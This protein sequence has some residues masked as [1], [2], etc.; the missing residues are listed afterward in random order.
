MK[1]GIMKMNKSKMNESMEGKRVVFYASEDDRVAVKAIS[2]LRK[3]GCI[4][5]IVGHGRLVP[6]GGVAFYTGKKNQGQEDKSDLPVAGCNVYGLDDVPEWAWNTPFLVRI[7]LPSGFDPERNK[8]ALE[9]VV[10]TCARRYEDW[11]VE[12]YPNRCPWG[13]PPTD[14]VHQQVYQKWQAWVS[15]IFSKVEKWARTPGLLSVKNKE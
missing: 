5:L 6:P 1:T 13:K 14:E 7:N 12:G 10:I 3:I 15:D 9:R 8:Q 4:A 11:F 2:I